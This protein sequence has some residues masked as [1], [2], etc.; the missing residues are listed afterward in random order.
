MYFFKNNTKKIRQIWA[1]IQMFLLRVTIEVEGEVD[2]EADMIVMNHQSMLDIIVLES[3]THR[4]LSW[5]AKKEIADIPW[6]GNILSLPKMIQVDRESKA[7][8][9]KLLKDS[10]DRIDEG[11]Q[12]AIFPEGTRT[13]GTKVIKFKAGAKMIAEKCSLTVQPVVIINTLYALDTK[14]M[15]QN[16]ATVKIIYLPTVNA[17]RK[18]EWYTSIEEQMR[19]T[20]TKE[21]N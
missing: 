21:I 17:V 2:N 4:N 9:V 13:D 5:V 8:L 18:T 15:K 1:K 14:L 16:K 3:M 10:K 20:L 11:R 7:S 19:E 12:I 6:F